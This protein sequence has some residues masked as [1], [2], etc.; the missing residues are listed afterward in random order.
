MVLTGSPVRVHNAI[1]TG[2]SFEDSN[3]VFLGFSMGVS[4]EDSNLVFLALYDLN[5]FLKLHIGFLPKSQ[6]SSLSSSL[7][8]VNE[9]QKDQVGN[10]N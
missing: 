1:S 8:L 5:N 2:V 6:Y 7:M 3:A 4:F 9:A 10:A